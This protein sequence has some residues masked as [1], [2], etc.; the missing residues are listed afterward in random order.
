VG[1]ITQLHP[2]SQ[3]LCLL[4]G[5]LGFWVV[6]AAAPATAVS[7]SGILIYSTDDFGNPNGYETFAQGTFQAQT[8]RTLVR[9]GQIW[10]G[11]GVTSGLPPQS[12]DG[13]FLNFPDFTI[14]IPL[15]EGENYFTLFA[16]PGP[17]TAGDD[18]QRFL[19]NLYFDGDNDRPGISVLFPRYADPD[20][21]E[22]AVAR[23]NDDQMYTLMLQQVPVTPQSYYDDGIHRVSV[24]RASLLA[25]ERANLSADRLTPYTLTPGGVDSDWIGTLT[26]SV[27]PTESFGAG[28][29]PPPFASGGSGGG[30]GAGGSD[31]PP[32]AGSAGYLPPPVGPVQQNPGRPDVGADAY[33]GADRE[34]A[35]P[36]QFWHKGGDPKD[37][38]E[39]NAGLTPT[40]EDIAG[41]FRAWLAE[42]TALTATAGQGATPTPAAPGTQGSPTHGTRT[43]VPPTPT[44]LAGTPT[45]VVTT[46]QSPVAA[47]TAPENA[48]N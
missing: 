30:R 41:A 46:T 23:P 9:G 18:F 28:G 3:R 20:G 39:A 19:V 42:E 32:R 24:L 44:R 1:P 11:L 47:G 6:A 15:D 10:Y 33:A 48:G 36:G 4:A 7:I 22:V 40:P 8:W 26:I 35:T 45:P 43:P 29:A 13:R 21:S 34:K 37:E 14:D 31:L 17:N 5:L 27:E 16:E 12:V 25:P 2:R 38:Q